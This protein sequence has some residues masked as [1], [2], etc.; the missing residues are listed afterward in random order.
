MGDLTWLIA[1]IILV[2]LVITY[3]GLKDEFFLEKY[4][5]HI[6][7]ILGQRQYIRM[8]SS[9]FLHVSWTHLFFNML[10]LYFFGPAVEYMLGIAGFL[11]LYSVSLVGG[12]LFALFVRRHDQDYR[13]IGASGAVSGVVFAAIALFPGMKLGL[14][15]IPIPMPGW[16]F[17]LAYVLYSIY[18]I[19]SR[20]DNIG[21]EAHLGGGVAGLLA[22]L[23]MRPAV[24]EFNYLPIILILVPSVIF[25]FILVLNPQALSLPGIRTKQ[26]H[27]YT[28]IDDD[29]HERRIRKQKELDRI[30]EKVSAKGIESLTRD[31]RR[32]LDENSG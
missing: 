28:T 13:A 17:G 23:A 19:R 18:G 8:L 27:P 31:E 16:F 11:V 4:T 21:H 29:Y 25:L 15:F 9:G 32:F 10:T 12:N 6:G 30:L 3:R 7:P 22:A 2:N 1:I 20:K 5:F 24:I 26:K 14:L